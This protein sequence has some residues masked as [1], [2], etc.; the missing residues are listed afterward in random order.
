MVGPV[1]TA[2]DLGQKQ[3]NQRLGIT[4][5]G[6]NLGS[7]FARCYL[8]CQTV[9]ALVFVDPQSG[10][11]VSDD[12]EQATI[13]GASKRRDISQVGFGPSPP[14]QQPI[15]GLGD[16]AGVPL[17][18]NWGCNH[19]CPV[20]VTLQ[21]SC[22]PVGFCQTI[23]S[24]EGDERRARCI[25][26]DIAG[27]TDEKRFVYGDQSDAMK[28]GSQHLVDVPPPRYSRQ[29]SRLVRSVR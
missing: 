22:G 4:V 27:R 6:H 29:R 23:T 12:V 8:V 18:K 16:K 17:R 19:P 21:P 9:E 14:I 15:G 2:P 24:E 7:P 1:L 11:K 3:L 26:A 5:P 13:V 10:R 28:V 20:P 25:D